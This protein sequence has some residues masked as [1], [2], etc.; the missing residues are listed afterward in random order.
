MQT[1]TWHCRYL[2]LTSLVE[3]ESAKCCAISTYN[4]IV[5]ISTTIKKGGESSGIF[6]TM[7]NITLVLKLMVCHSEDKKNHFYIFTV[8]NSDYKEL[9]N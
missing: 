4:V 1:I 6:G 7:C 8:L 9:V 5:F 2:N 3:K